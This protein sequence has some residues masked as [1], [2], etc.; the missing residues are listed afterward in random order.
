VDAEP[1]AGLRTCVLKMWFRVCLKKE[2]NW[3][4]RLI[5]G[6]FTLRRAAFC[7]AFHQF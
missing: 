6:Q 3:K 2:R 7:P 4:F 5:Y 1:S